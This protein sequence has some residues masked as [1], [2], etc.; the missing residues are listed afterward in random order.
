MASGAATA[1]GAATAVATATGAATAVATATGAV[2][3]VATATAA[4]KL[5]TVKSNSYSTI[6]I[7]TIITQQQF[8][9]SL[10]NTDLWQ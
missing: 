7:V 2:T 3:T 10:M 8:D 1:T 6:K 4:I 5:K 9:E